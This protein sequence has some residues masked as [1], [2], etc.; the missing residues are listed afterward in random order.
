MRDAIYVFEDNWITIVDPKTN[1]IAKRIDNNTKILGSDG[2]FCTPHPRFRR[3]CT[4]FNAQYVPDKYIFAI[5]LYGG[6]VI[7]IDIEKQT[8]VRAIKT[9]D[10]AKTLRYMA[11]TD[12]VWVMC[13]PKNLTINII[14]AQNGGISKSKDASS[15]LVKSS[16]KIKV[17]TL[18][19]GLLISCKYTLHFYLT[20]FKKL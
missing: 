15:L 1:Q 13:W 14:G 16:I 5:D 4:L 7:V 12:E 6:R 3:S 9:N 19:E 8:P 20:Y 18:W 2:S 11:E 10:P 17:S